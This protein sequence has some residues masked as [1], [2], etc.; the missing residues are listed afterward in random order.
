[1]PTSGT[2]STTVFR[3]Q[4]VIDHAF[5]RVKLTP[6]QIT[7]EHISTARDIL[8]LQLSAMLNR[9]MPLWTIQSLLLPM[10][11][12]NPTVPC[13]LGVVNVL[14]VNIR[15][16]QRVTGTNDA[17]EGDA[18][19]AFDGDLDTACTQT[20]PNG[21]IQCQ[22]SS[23]TRIPCFGI[24]PNASGTWSYELQGS[25]DGST[26]TAFYTATEEAVV[27]GEWIWFDVEQM[28]E[29]EYIRLRATDGTILNVTEL[30]FSNTPTSIPLAL[31]NR[32]DY[33]N[34]PNRQFLGRPTEYWLDKQQDLQLM[35]V[36][37]NV[38]AQFTFAQL[39]TQVQ[40]YIQDVGS[41]RQNLN[42]P[43]RW[44]DAVVWN[45]AR[46]CA[47]EIKEADKDMISVCD[48][49]YREAI[50]DAWDGESDRA[51][52]YFVPNIRPYTRG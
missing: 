45:L 37:P 48:A 9:G 2:T 33:Y 25:S 15:T 41:L 24:L 12:A 49:R 29:W 13:P 11:I 51:P 50:R 27:D 4:K 3:T 8:F 52:S 18:D 44:Y 7:A 32:D 21:Y 23:A 30:M 10:Y 19:D 38:Q 17:S 36:W 40:Y 46:D 47:I 14:N 22:F 35:R 1:M 31:I 26:F 43:Q 6:Q 20:T 42:V 39:E 5:R 28:L 34:I 16:V